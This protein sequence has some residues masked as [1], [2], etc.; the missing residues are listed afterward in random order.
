MFNVTSGTWRQLAMM[1]DQVSCHQAV[2]Q[3]VTAVAGAGPAQ[4]RLL[5]GRGRGG[6]GLDARR[7]RDQLRHQQ[8]RA[9]V[10][11]GG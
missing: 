10:G 11:G 4:L 8:Q 5:G 6:R 7:G 3:A 1:P 2:I 9:L